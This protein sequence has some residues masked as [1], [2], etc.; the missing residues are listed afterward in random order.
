MLIPPVRHEI[1]LSV[2]VRSNNMLPILTQ[3][4]WIWFHVNTS[5]Q[6]QFFWSNALFSHIHTHNPLP[7]TQFRLR[8]HIFICLQRTYICC[9]TQSRLLKRQSAANATRKKS[10]MLCQTVFRLKVVWLNDAAPMFSITLCQIH[11]ASTCL[12][13][14]AKFLRDDLQLSRQSLNWSY[15]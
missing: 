4:R 3:L 6:F 2:A 11:F 12:Y 5:V 15:F 14:S 10:K 13:F 9:S 8:E 7:F 1:V